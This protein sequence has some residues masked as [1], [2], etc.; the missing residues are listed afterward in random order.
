TEVRAAILAV[1]CIVHGY[2][3]HK[4]LLIYM[5]SQYAIKSFCYWAGDNETRGWGC[6]NGDDLRDAVGWLALRQAPVE[7]RWI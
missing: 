3:V 5:A 6:A 1:L 2:P 4:Q 7:F